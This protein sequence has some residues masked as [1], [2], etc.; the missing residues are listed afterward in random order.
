M[1]ISEYSG[2]MKGGDNMTN[3]D[4]LPELEWQPTLDELEKHKIPATNISHLYGLISTAQELY[5][6]GGT[7][8]DVDLIN[9]MGFIRLLK[10][11]E[12]E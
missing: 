4:G 8:T 7:V 9:L 11:T 2:T 3:N 5:N 10:I 1:T 6:N 12:T